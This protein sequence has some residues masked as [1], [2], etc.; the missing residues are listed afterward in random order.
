MT[1]VHNNNNFDYPIPGPQTDLWASGRRE[2]FSKIPNVFIYGLTNLR[3]TLFPPS[4][5]SNNAFLNLKYPL[6]NIL[7]RNW[8]KKKKKKE[9]NRIG[10]SHVCFW[11]LNPIFLVTLPSKLCILHFSPTLLYSSI[12]SFPLV[13]L[14]SLSTVYTLGLMTPCHRRLS[15]VS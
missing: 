14:H 7:F 3:S 6:L 12:V 10:C 4:I 1:L 11:N 13:R 8:Q 5:A 9:K 2:H 15:C